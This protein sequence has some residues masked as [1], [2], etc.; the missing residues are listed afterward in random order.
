MS[1]EVWG[2]LY[3]IA[4]TYLAAH[5]LTLATLG[6]KTGVTQQRL[7]QE[8]ESYMTLQKPADQAYYLTSYGTQF[9]ALRDMLFITPLAGVGGISEFPGTF[10]AGC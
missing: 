2:P 5:L 8:S 6:G 1:A 7:G 3:D 9:L 4:Q 10:F